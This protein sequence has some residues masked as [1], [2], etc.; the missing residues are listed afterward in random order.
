[1]DDVATAVGVS[2]ATVSNAYNRADQLS[3]E[4]RAEIFRTAKLLGYTGPNPT[5]RSLATH[6]TGAIAFMLDAGLS[7]AFSDPALAITLDALAMEVDPAGHSL[8]LLPGGHD[9]GPRADQVLSA[10]ADVAVAYSLG[11]GAPAL[12]AVRDR[13]LPLVL[14]DQSP[15]SGAAV[16]GTDDRGGASAVA[17]HLVELGHRRF[18]IVSAQCLSTPRGGPLSAAEA[19][20]S[21]FRDNRERLAG[22]LETLADAGVDPAKV[23]IWE[24]SGLS[25]ESALTGARGL[26]EQRPDLTAVLCMSDELAMATISMAKQLGR[27]VPT[28]LSVVGF[29]DTPGARWADPPLTT[30]RQDLV[31]KGRLAGELTLLLLA[32]RRP[33][34]PTILDIEL[35]VRQSTAPPPAD[36]PEF[37]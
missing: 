18:G 12:R 3:A 9:G 16:V 11:D 23:P 6:R 37:H 4:L 21:R 28:D 35:I 1:M 34:K 13:G 24:A 14:I 17:R 22:Y 25:R 5:A 8:L 20:K 7:A 36:T 32:G 31:R 29:D 26:L 30:V 15:V 27:G 33:P 19:A 2:R 10:Q